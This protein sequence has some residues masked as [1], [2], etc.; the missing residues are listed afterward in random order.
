M[1]SARETDMTGY[2]IGIML[3]F[4]TAVATACLQRK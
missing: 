4:F 3:I 2:D 1:A